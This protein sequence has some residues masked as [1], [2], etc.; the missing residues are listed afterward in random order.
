MTAVTASSVLVSSGAASLVPASRLRGV[1]L[2]RVGV[3]L[4]LVSVLLALISIPIVDARLARARTSDAAR[5]QIA[6]QRATE[7]L[8]DKTRTIF[9]TLGPLV[10]LSSLELQ[11]K[12]C[13][14][15]AASDAVAASLQQ[16][17]Q[18][19]PLGLRMLALRNAQ[20]EMVVGFGQDPD[21]SP[22]EPLSENGVGLPWRA[23]DGRHVMHVTKILP[24]YPGATLRVTV[25]LDALAAAADVAS[26]PGSM[27]CLYRLRDGA[28]LSSLSLDAME[29]PNAPVMPVEY[30]D[31]PTINRFASNERGWI[32]E[33]S[34]L[35]TSES[36]SFVTLHE[37]GL[38]VTAKAPTGQLSTLSSLRAQSLRLLPVF[39]LL[40]G[41]SV[42]ALVLVVATRQRARAALAREHRVAE[43]EASARAE[44]EHL[45]SCSP[46]MLYRGRLTPDNEFVRDF[47]TPNTAEVTGW[48]PETLSNPDLVW[49]LLTD[50]DRQ[51]R[52]NNYIRAAREG[53]SA[54]EYRLQRPDGSF[55]WLRNEAVRVR[56]DADGSC[57]L[58]GAITNITRERE[59]SAYAG[60]QNRLASLGQI[61]ASLAHE[62]TQPMTVI[63]MAAAIASR[64]VETLPESD[65]IARHLK[66]IHDQTERASD[67]IRHLRAYGRMDG[68]P[69]ADISLL[70][71]TNGA[72]DLVNTALRG[73]NVE[74]K[75][76][77]PAGLPVVRARQVQV[78]QILVNLLINA[79][80]AMSGN[81]ANARR[82]T[83]RGSAAGQ[84]VRLD[85]EDTGPGVP[86]GM[87]TRLFEP[88]FTTKVSGDGTGLGLSL[89]QT[90]MHQFGGSISVANGRTGA[91]FTLE[92]PRPN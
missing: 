61:S 22:D 77:I 45:V 12:S 4:S 78:E 35:G 37:L 43:A 34:A 47:L 84:S 14:D 52:A 89:C 13:C 53:R 3:A 38:V 2:M 92:F 51:R 71:A 15:V 90:M 55:S 28:M 80:D 63:G 41:L 18:Q 7:A 21:E 36:L 58:A 9:G 27:T 16:A 56:L 72:L 26:P 48:P 67:I 88:F 76:E 66:T 1:S 20:G 10:R 79:R 73:S 91:V 86:N 29:M 49:D 69:M 42:T 44:L 85:V 82:V 17:M 31:T 23:P 30:L 50:E 11:M 32:N 8:A 57:E 81:P 70:D 65:Q 87:I 54:V 5:S 74:V 75:L 33:L 62:L 25:D 46:A 83:L 19:S 68:G 59:I 64:H 39:V 40:F 6:M 24:T 60:M